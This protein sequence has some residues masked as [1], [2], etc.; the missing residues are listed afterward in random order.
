[1]TFTVVSPGAVAAAVV[2]MPGCGVLFPNWNVVWLPAY[3]TIGVALV[4]SLTGAA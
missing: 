4:A 3:P 1:M 2:V